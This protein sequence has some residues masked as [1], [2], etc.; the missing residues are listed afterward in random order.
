MTHRFTLRHSAEISDIHVNVR[1]YNH[2]SGAVF[3]SVHNDDE[4]K[5]FAVTLRTPPPDST[6]VAHILE[7]SVLCGSKRFP[8]KSPFVELMK[9]SLNTFMNAMTFP[10]K[11]IY[12]VAST[13]LKDL[14]NLVDV[15]MDAVFHPL[16]EEDTLRQEGWRFEFDDANKLT[17]KGIVFNEMK[18]ASVTPE[19]VAYRALMAGLFPDTIYAHDSG[20]DPQVIPALTY[21]DFVAFHHTYYHPSN[22]LIYWYGDDDEDARLAHLEPYLATFSAQTQPTMQTMQPRWQVPRQMTVPYPASADETRHHVNVAWQIEVSDD[23]VDTMEIAIVNE[24]LLGS[25]VAPL[26]KMLRD[27]NLGEELSGGGFGSNKQHYFVLGLKGVQAENITRVIAAVDGAID[28]IIRDGVEPDQILATL[29]NFEFRLRELSYGDMPKGLGI[30]MGLCDEW[31]HDDNVSDEMLNAFRYEE[32]L[33]AVKTR[34]ADPNRIPTLLRQLISNNQHRLELIVA[35]DATLNAQ[36]D[37]REQQTLAAKEASLTDAERAQIVADAERLRVKQ[38]TPDDPIQLNKLPRLTR[39]D[40]D[41]KAS[42]TPFEIGDVVGTPFSY[43][44][45]QTNGIAYIHVTFSLA[46]IPPE[47]LS[48]LPI[49]VNALDSIGAGPFDATKLMQQIDIHTGGISA[50]TLWGRN[51]ITGDT[52][53]H[54]LF[55]GRAVVA[56][57]ATMF[58]LMTHMITAPHLHNRERILQIIKE[59]KASREARLLPSGHA[60]INTRLRAKHNPLANITEQLGGITYL[61]FIRTLAERAEADWDG[62][63]HNLQ[64][65]HAAIFHRNSMRI[66]VVCSHEHIPALQTASADFL[67]ALPQHHVPTTQWPQVDIPTNEALIATSQVNYVGV[68][69]SLHTLGYTASGADIV[70]NRYLSQS[71]LHEQIREKGGAYGAFSVLEIRSGMLTMLS[72]RDPNIT[73]TLDV[74]AQAGAWLQQ[75]T[76]DEETLL[77]SI[78]GASGDLDNYMLPATRGFTAFS[79]YLNGVDHAY[80]QRIRDQA[81]HVTNEDFARYGEILSRAAQQWEAIVL[82]GES[83]ITQARESQPGLF[84]TSTKVQ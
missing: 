65:I 77:Q 31:V 7:H 14:Y 83:A 28:T 37:A 80:R 52:H 53:G 9:G 2:P 38:S 62:I 39:Q 82:G 20:G 45:L 8:V 23:A 12:P 68:V 55:S 46:H 30:M 19:R 64:R 17:Y 76:L 63:Y 73:Q 61:Q 29:N 21:A 60:V 79:D 36:Y 25:A 11:T 35:P 26:Q 49:Y 54:V 4:N 18:G 56:N 57:C 22:A 3:V 43:A 40:I 71:Y 84:G 15:Y 78:I 16:I 34:L 24:A 72:Y 32:S 70:V 51:R 69:A 81:L 6:G 5:C 74:Y 33:A 41:E 27:S 67:A 10:D 66:N 13:N 44:P 1:I 58:S 48:Y 59:D 50:S 47:L 75:V 42:D